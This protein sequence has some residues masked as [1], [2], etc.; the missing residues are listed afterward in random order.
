[1][2]ELTYREAEAKAVKVLA[3]GVGEGL[4]LLGEGGYYALYYFFSLYGRKAPHPEETPDWVEGP[5]PSPEGFRPPYD[6]ARW[7]E[8]HG[9]TLFVNESK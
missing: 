8:A 1:V 5:K 6:Q 4:V 7:L 9:Y 3:D 2:R